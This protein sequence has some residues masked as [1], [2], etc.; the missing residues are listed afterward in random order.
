MAMRKTLYMIWAFNYLQYA[1]LPVDATKSYPGPSSSIMHEL[2][3]NYLN[4]P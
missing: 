4:P 3:S 2:L 1:F